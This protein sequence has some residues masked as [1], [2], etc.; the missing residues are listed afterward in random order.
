MINTT[1]YTV[2]EVADILKVKVT[3]VRNQIALGNIKATKML[4]GWRI[5]QEELDRILRGE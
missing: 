2:K 3:T 4:G 5:K 1:L